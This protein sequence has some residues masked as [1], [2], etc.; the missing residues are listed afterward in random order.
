[1][2]EQALEVLRKRSLVKSN[3]EKMAKILV[4]IAIKQNKTVDEVYT[5]ILSI[6]K[7]IRG[8]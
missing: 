5:D 6:V 2:Y 4:K 8:A 3:H 7:Q 1:M